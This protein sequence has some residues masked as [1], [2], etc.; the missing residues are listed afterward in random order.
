MLINSQNKRCPGIAG[1]QYGLPVLRVIFANLVYPPLR[2]VPH[3]LRALFSQRYQ[4]ITLTQK[5]SQAAVN[6]AGLVRRGLAA[7]GGLYC[8]INQGMRGVGGIGFIPYQGQHHTQQGIGLRRRRSFGELLAQRLGTPQ[9]AQ[10]MKTQRLNAGAQRAV[11][12]FKRCSHGLP[13]FDR[14]EQGRSAL[15]LA[16]KRNLGRDV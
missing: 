9:P 2:V 4:R 10:R 13:V 7:L 1:A 5:T 6:K 11:N 15:Q 8:L 16:P 3:C 12:I 14:H